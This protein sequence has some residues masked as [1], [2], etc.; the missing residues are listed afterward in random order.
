[1]ANPFFGEIQ[2]KGLCIPQE[3]AI[4]NVRLARAYVPFQRLCNLFSP[5]EALEKGTVFPELYSPYFKKEH[6]KT[7]MSPLMEKCGDDYE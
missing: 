3:T 5:E 4:T 7:K 6:A 2:H 1:M